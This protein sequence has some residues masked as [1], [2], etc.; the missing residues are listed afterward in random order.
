MTFQRW[1]R[2]PLSC[3]WMTVVS[4]PLIICTTSLDIW[5]RNRVNVVVRRSRRR[6][7]VMSPMALSRSRRVR[8]GATAPDVIEW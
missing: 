8:T 4:M 5:S 6:I 7:I 3:H 2:P 1:A